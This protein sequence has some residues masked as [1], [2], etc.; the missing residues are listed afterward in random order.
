MALAERQA[1]LFQLSFYRWLKVDFR[2]SRVTSDGGLAMVRELDDRMGLGEPIARHL[3]ASRGKNNQ[4]HLPDA[5][6]Q[7]VPSRP[8]GYQDL[9]DTGGC[10]RI[11]P[12]S[13]AAR[14]GSGSV[15][16][17]SPPACSHWRRNC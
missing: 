6:R 8:A 17:R 10:P 12:F 15:A 9:N 1:Q 14:E 11:R 7:S 16:H 13:F 2:G 4:S 5:V 3:A